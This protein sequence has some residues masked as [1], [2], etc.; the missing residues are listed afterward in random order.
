V[1]HHNV[2][3]CKESKAIKSREIIRFCFFHIEVIKD[4]IA[5]R[6]GKI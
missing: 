1:K 5:T 4:F 6:I 2:N 3:A